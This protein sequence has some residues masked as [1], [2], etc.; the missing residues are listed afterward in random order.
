MTIQSFVEDILDSGRIQPMIRDP[1]MQFLDP[2]SGRQFLGASLFPRQI[3]DKNEYTES[4]VQLMIFPARDGSVYSPPIHETG[5]A[6][7]S[8]IVRLGHVMTG[9]S[10]SGDDYEQIRRYF[11]INESLG[12][13]QLLNWLTQVTA[14]ALAIKGEIQSMDLLQDGQVSVILNGITHNV[15]Y[16]FPSE[17]RFNATGDWNA[18]TDGVSDHDPFEDLQL[19]YKLLNDNGFDV[20]R[21]ITSTAVASV[22][23]ANTKVRNYAGYLN[24]SGGVVQNQQPITFNNLGMVNEAMLRGT[25]SS[26]TIPPMETYDLNYNIPDA[27]TDTAAQ[28]SLSKRRKYFLKRNVV[29]VIGKTNQDYPILSED[30]INTK[31]LGTQKD[32][33]GYTG[34]GRVPTYDES[35]IISKVWTSD[36][37]KDK[38]NSVNAEAYA[39]C[40]PVMTVRGGEAVVVIE[41]INLS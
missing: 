40:A 14:G 30:A 37:K 31:I 11:G 25:R 22:M 21:Q 20:H 28:P 19:A 23:A 5:F 1:R 7:A 3:K 27:G 13:Q 4:S 10:L 29:V 36:S 38:L 24:L 41:N 39:Q 8:G 9:A 17:N 16:G 2:N 12:Q 32:A 26:G 6:Q 34:M 35:G 15:N 33:L 18:K